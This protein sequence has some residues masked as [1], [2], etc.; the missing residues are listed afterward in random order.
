M[1]YI[2][3]AIAGASGAIARY[4]IHRLTLSLGNN[5]LIGTFIVNISGSFL[6]WF[7]ISLFAYKF[8]V[9]NT[10]KD[11]IIIGFIGSYTTFSTLT[12]ASLTLWQSGEYMKS[13]FNIIFSIIFG[14]LAAWIGFYLGK[15]FS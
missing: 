10:I 8:N 15:Q 11:A 4:G 9:S 2:L 5:S 6:L 3:I 14:L 7:L 13:L 1:N 12:V